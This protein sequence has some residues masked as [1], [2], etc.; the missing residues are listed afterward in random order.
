MLNTLLACAKSALISLNNSNDSL[1][2]N[3]E[4]VIPKPPINFASLIIPITA[5]FGLNLAI[6]D[7]N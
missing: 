3:T 7:N 5:V 1:A 4:D 2:T 6:V